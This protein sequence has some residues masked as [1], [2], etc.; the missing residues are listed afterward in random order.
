MVS[1]TLWY[2]VDDKLVILFHIE[3]L[4]FN[5]HISE[6]AEAQNYFF[7]TG[8]HNLKSFGVTDGEE[9]YKML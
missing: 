4:F 6:S 9:K 8:L 1:L 3:I 5:I 2:V 7:W